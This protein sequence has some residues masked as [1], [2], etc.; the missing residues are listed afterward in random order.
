MMS[1]VPPRP[2]GA[3]VCVC[4]MSEHGSFEVSCRFSALEINSHCTDK[5]KSNRRPSLLT[6]VSKVNKSLMKLIT[7]HHHSFPSFQV[8][9]MNQPIEKIL[10]L[11]PHV[12]TSMNPEC[13]WCVFSIWNLVII[14]DSVPRQGSGSRMEKTLGARSNIFN[15]KTFGCVLFPS[16]CESSS[17]FPK[18]TWRLEGTNE[19]L[20]LLYIQPAL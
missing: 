6:V 20:F 12:F 16:R 8:D 11:L 19:H 18:V 1:D 9:T 10:S 13:I 17:R 14:S 4:E 5:A 7:L 2:S 15:R 3:C